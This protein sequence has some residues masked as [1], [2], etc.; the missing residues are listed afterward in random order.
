MSKAQQGLTFI[1]KPW[2]QLTPKFSDLATSRCMDSEKC[3]KLVANEKQSVILATQQV[4]L[5]TILSCAQWYEFG[6]KNNFNYFYN[7]ANKTQ[8]KEHSLKNKKMTS[9]IF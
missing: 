3:E 2:G 5:C 9:N 6:E 7:L 4:E 1:K 8:E